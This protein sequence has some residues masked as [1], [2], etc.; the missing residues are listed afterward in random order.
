M[1]KRAQSAYFAFSEVMRSTVKED[2]VAEAESGKIS[3][4][5]VAKEIGRRWKALAEE[6]RQQYKDRAAE[7]A[8]AFAEAAAAANEG[9]E[10]ADEH[11]AP[12]AKKP[13]LLPLSIVKKVMVLDKDVSR[14]SSEGVWLMA[15]AA[16]CFLEMLTERCA[17]AALSRKRRTIKMDELEHVIRRDKKLVEVGLKAVLHTPADK[18]ND[19]P[20]E[21]DSA[22]AP[23]T[24]RQKKETSTTHKTVK[25]VVEDPKVQKITSFFTKTVQPAAK[26]V[27]TEA[28]S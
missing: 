13:A 14:V 11:P 7:S 6:E 26:V 18:E 15:R 9:D 21:D 8:K 23:A 22:E 27:A 10:A 25:K 5:E 12:A 2:L 1:A 3:V 24:K 17:T 4:A 28:S 16:E 19:A 20:A